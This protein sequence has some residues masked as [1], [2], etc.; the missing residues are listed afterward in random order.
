MVPCQGGDWI[1]QRR[2]GQGPYFRFAGDGGGW[3]LVSP[4]LGDLGRGMSVGMTSGS[5]YKKRSGTILDDVVG[6]PLDKH[7]NPTGIGR[8]QDWNERWT[9]ANSDQGAWLGVP[10]VRGKYLPVEILWDPIIKVR[11]WYPWGRNSPY[12]WSGTYGYEGY[13]TAGDEIGRDY[14]TRKQAGAFGYSLF[15]YSVGCAAG[16]HDIRNGD[17][18][19]GSGV[20]GK[21]QPFRY[22]TRS[23]DMRASHKPST[24]IASCHPPV[25]SYQ[26]TRYYSS[27]F[28][29]RDAVPGGWRF[30]VGHID[31]HVDDAKWMEARATWP[32]NSALADW[33]FLQQSFFGVPYGWRF[34]TLDR[35]QMPGVADTNLEPI[36]GFPLPFD[37][38]R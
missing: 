17:W 26:F 16:K 31:G 6:C 34:K 32:T 9:S 23:N 2:V 24:W 11:S 36:P 35:A 1:G 29:Y 21:E 20:K 38:N 7:G 13:V 33:L 10:R 3:S 25:S 8:G 22:A 4:D 5:W 18:S 19:Y 37:C 14:L 12:E 30:N 28:G 15:T 27:H